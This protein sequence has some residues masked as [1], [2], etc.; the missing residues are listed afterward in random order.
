MKNKNIFK[1]KILMF[2]LTFLFVYFITVVFDYFLNLARYSEIREAYNIITLRKQTEDRVYI[3]EAKK[4]NF[5]PL[6]LP[7]VY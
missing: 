6:I 4:N 5:S 1:Y 7:F 3:K 2:F